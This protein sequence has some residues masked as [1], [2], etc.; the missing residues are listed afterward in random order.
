VDPVPEP[1]LF[2]SGSV[3]NRTRASKPQRR[4]YAE[5]TSRNSEGDFT[6]PGLCKAVKRIL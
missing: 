4:S 2:F 1:L 6:A 3:G 5:Y